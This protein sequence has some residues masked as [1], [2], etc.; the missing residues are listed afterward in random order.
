MPELNLKIVGEAMLAKG[1]EALK[2][3]WAAARPYATTEFRKL[4]ETGKMIVDGVRDGSINPAQAR[5]LLSM[6][7]GASRAVLTAIEAIGIIAAQ[8]AIN[9]ALGVLK[10]AINTAAGFAVL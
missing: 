8:D 1:E 3:H 5:I 9:A 10:E 2:G 4:A 6:Q 7:E